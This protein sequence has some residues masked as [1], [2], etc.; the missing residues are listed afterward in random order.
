[1]VSVTS[2]V[3]VAPLAE[4]V[5]VLGVEEPASSSA[6]LAVIE[7]DEGGGW[8]VGGAGVIRGSL[9]E[10]AEQAPTRAPMA[11]QYLSPRLLVA[12]TLLLTGLTAGTRR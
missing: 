4:T 3:P 12:I 5:I 9:G 8:G 7:R 10:S 11:I 1:V 6:G 2:P